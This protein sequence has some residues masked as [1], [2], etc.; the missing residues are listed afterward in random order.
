VDILHT[1]DDDSPHF[2]ERFVRTHDADRIALYE[3]VATRKELDSLALRQ[4]APLVIP[5]ARSTCLERASIRPNNPLPA[6]DE[7]F[8]VPDEAANFYNVACDRVVED[9]DGLADGGPSGEEFNEVAG[10]ED[11]IGVPCFAGCAD[12]HGAM[13]EIECACYALRE[14]LR[15]EGGI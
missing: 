4:Y 2:F 12:G 8:L 15:S 11:D 5:R 9:F 10:L 14:A 7:A 13:N 3:D 6:L 1:V